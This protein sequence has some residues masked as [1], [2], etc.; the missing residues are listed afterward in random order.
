[1]LM[2]SG[3]VVILL[4]SIYAILG[5]VMGTCTM[6][7]ADGLVIGGLVAAMGYS[8][9]MGLLIAPPP[10]K[11]G[12]FLLLPVIGAVAYQAYLAG[13]FFI[14]YHLHSLS[15]CD[16]KEGS[17]GFDPDGREPWLTALW[18]GISALG[19]VGFARAWLRG[20]KSGRVCR[21]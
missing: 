4:S 14:A 11:R 19:L 12:W 5:T 10:N 15:A 6:G 3:G 20:R 17:P 8:I 13:S 16:W 9:G 2:A 18:V 7:S 1:M 21:V